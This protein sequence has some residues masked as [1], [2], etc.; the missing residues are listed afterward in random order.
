MV[1]KRDLL[2]LIV[3]YHPP[4]SEVENLYSCL[5]QL[6]DNIGY[7]IVAND[8][9]PGEPVDKLF[10]HSDC[11]LRNKDNLG[12]GRAVNKLISQLS[13]KPNLIGVLNT[14]LGW[15][16]GTFE[17]MINWLYKN[18]DVGLLVPQIIDCSGQIQRLCKKIQLS[19]EC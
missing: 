3:A 6:P 14:D 19:L 1:M 12:Y 13:Y 17:T 15:A 2:L 5:S 9:K 8:Y 4:L 11:A 10:A 16:Q 18:P 7:A